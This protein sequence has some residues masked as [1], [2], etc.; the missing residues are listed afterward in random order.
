MKISIKYRFQLV[1]LLVV[2]IRHSQVQL[3]RH[4]PLQQVSVCVKTP[5]HCMRGCQLAHLGRFCRART[6]RTRIPDLELE[7]SCLSFEVILN[8]TE[9]A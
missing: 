5:L 6:R 1:Y 8:L 3:G 9:F 2:S 7:K 4:L